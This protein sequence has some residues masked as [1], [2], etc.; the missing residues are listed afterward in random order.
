MSKVDWQLFRDALI[1]L[2]EL[3]SPDGRQGFTEWD[4]WTQIHIDNMMIAHG[5]N[6]FFPWH[7]AYVLALEQRLQR[8]SPNVTIPYWD[9]TFDW[10]IPL[11]SPIF[12]PEYGLDVI[13]GIGGDCR[14][15]RNV[16]DPHCLTRDYNATDFT[17]FYSPES[18]SS[19]ITSESNYT[20][21]RELIEMVPH[22]I[23]HTSLGGEHGDMATMN[24]PNDPIFFL[25][26]SMVDFVWWIWQR[27]F[28]NRMNTFDGDENQVL[29]PFGVTVRDVLGNNR[30]CTNYKPFSLNN[31]L[32]PSTAK[33][34]SKKLSKR[35]IR[36]DGVRIWRV[37]HRWLLMNNISI[38]R[39][40]EIVNR[41][42]RLAG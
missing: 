20:S 25:H 9:W 38:D 31:A 13:P 28:P 14:Y 15:L 29:E 21:F 35:A 32:I 41:F 36:N 2:Q 3:P 39:L 7:R 6:L 4:Y 27:T 1:S 33:F 11:G 16:F 24:S 17:T 10:E 8:T 12:S 34:N 22:A 26:H 30:F 37:P 5:S 40:Q 42:N 18:V 19:V 23:V